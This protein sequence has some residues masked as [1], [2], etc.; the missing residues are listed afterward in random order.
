MKPA[1]TDY[2]FKEKRTK[3]KEKKALYE[4]GIRAEQ[5]LCHSQEKAH[6]YV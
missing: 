5:K 2:K 6:A 4:H 3:V 1:V